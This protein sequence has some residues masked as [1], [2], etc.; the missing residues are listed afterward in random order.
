MNKERDEAIKRQAARAAWMLMMNVYKRPEP[1]AAVMEAA[2]MIGVHPGALKT[3]F[4]LDEPKSMSS[5][6]DVMFCDASYVTSVADDLEKANY[7]E[8]IVS[9]NDRRV[10]LLTRTKQ[11]DMALQEAKERIVDPPEFMMKASEQDLQDLARLLDKIL[12]EPTKK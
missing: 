10:K 6:A 3:L 11:G 2:D 12:E 7:I 1:N 8:R 9:P 5:I 4:Y